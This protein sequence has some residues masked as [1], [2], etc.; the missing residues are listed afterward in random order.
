MAPSITLTLDERRPLL[1]ATVTL[2]GQAARIS[3]LRNDYATV[4]DQATGLGAE[5]A[6]PTVRHIIENKGG[7]FQSRH[8]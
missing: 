1:H 4:T 6:W 8:G 3:G 5:W 7:A 2:N